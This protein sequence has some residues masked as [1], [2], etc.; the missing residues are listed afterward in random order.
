M[1]G[2]SRVRGRLNLCEA[3]RIEDNRDG[4]QLLFFHQSDLY[5]GPT[6]TADPSPHSVRCS[7]RCSSRSPKALPAST[8]RYGCEFMS[9][10]SGHAVACVHVVKRRQ[11]VHGIERSLSCRLRWR[12]QHGA[13]AARHRIAGDQLLASSAAGA[14][15]A[16][17]TSCERIPIG[18]GRHYHVADDASTSMIVQDSTRHFTLHSIVD[19]R[20]RDEGR[21]SR[22]RSRC[23]STTRCCPPARGGRTCCSPTGYGKDGCSSLATPCASR[24]P[25]RRAWHE[26]RRRRR[27]RPVVETRRRRCQ[28]WGGPELLRPTRSSGG[29][30]ARAMWKPRVMPHAAGG[31][32]ARPGNP[33]FATRRRKVPQRGPISRALPMSSSARAT[34]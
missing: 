34:R 6:S 5:V 15:S 11:R 3:L 18:K 22:R 21:C 31:P 19:E 28:G 10:D 17:T 30:S 32:G 24:H 20:S 23:R 26:Q 16:A 13:Q 2:F 12:R 4:P 14:V 1:D 9:F 8:V 33:I 25:D 29:R 7:S 27:Y